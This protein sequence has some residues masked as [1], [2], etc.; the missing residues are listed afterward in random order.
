MLGLRLN[1]HRL[2]VVILP[3]YRAG[4]LALLDSPTWKPYRHIFHASQA[5]T[6][7]G[8]LSRL[9]EGVY[10]VHHIVSHMYTSITHALA[11]NAE[12]LNDSLEEFKNW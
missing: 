5:Q 1:T 7:V 4:V 8:E 2:S 11:K 3:K 10:W 12:F 9:A 6:F